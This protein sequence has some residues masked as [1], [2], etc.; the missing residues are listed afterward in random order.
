MSLFL[1]CRL[2]NRTRGRKDDLSGEKVSLLFFFFFWFKKKKHT[3]KTPTQIGSWK[4]CQNF[5]DRRTEF[6]QVS[7]NL[8][9]QECYWTRDTVAGFT[10]VSYR[11]VRGIL[12]PIAR[13]YSARNEASSRTWDTSAANRP[14]SNALTVIWSRRRRPT[15][16]SIYAGN[17]RGTRSTFRIFIYYQIWPFEPRIRRLILFTQLLPF[18]FFFFLSSIFRSWT[19]FFFFSFSSLSFL[20]HA[21]QC[22]FV[23]IRTL[24][25]S[26]DFSPT[27]DWGFTLSFNPLRSNDDSQAPLGSITPEVTLRH[28]SYLFM[29]DFF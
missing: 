16:R 7:N 23:F 15:Y 19:K 13:A 6:F 2:L 26:C 9:R 17:T 20:L 1:L 4:H 10:E 22:Q 29:F 25:L 21:L 12:A 18:F 24:L 27:S 14:A 5:T 3:T 11:T 8:P 28:H